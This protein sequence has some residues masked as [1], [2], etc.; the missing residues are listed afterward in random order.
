MP[1]TRHTVKIVEHICDLCGKRISGDPITSPYVASN[2]THE[3]VL[4]HK[5]NCYWDITHDTDVS[6]IE[7]DI[8]PTCFTERLLPILRCMIVHP[9]EYV[10]NSY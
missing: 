4:K 5:E 3:V 7:F 9:V 6:E 10:K 2:I 1:E 8:C